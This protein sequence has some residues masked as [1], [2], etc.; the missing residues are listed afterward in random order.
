[1]SL[2]ALVRTQVGALTLDVALTADAG[3]VVALLGPNGAGKTSVLRVLAGLRPLAAGHVRL[4]DEVLD[5]PALDR[6]VEP[7][8]RSIALVFQD[9][10]LFGTM[11][12]LENVAFGLRARGTPKADARHRA[13][14][15]LAALGLRDQAGA[16]P[17]ALSGGQQQ[18][19]ALARA[20]VLSPALLLLDE[21]LAAL[22]ART[23]REVRRELRRH[24]TEFGGAAI[25]VTHDPVDAFA[26]A[27]R[28]V[29]IEHGTVVQQGALVE[30]AARPRSRYVAELVGVNLLQGE[31]QGER[32]V[33][34]TGAVLHTG[35]SEV[36]DGPAMAVVHP[37]AV[38]LHRAKPEG[39]PRNVWSA[40]VDE[41][42]AFGDRARVRLAP[43]SSGHPALTAEI[44][45]DSLVQLHALVGTELWVSVKAT[46]IDTFAM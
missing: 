21:P 38:A 35:A 27:D 41:N 6:F 40:V 2:D 31:R 36:P 7:A 24:L 33:C 8:D 22:D 23:H 12:A 45:P 43:S 34:E 15:Q 18:R 10:L 5:E 11:S 26:L 29:V 13:A 1:M 14:E 3:E 4:N 44:T 46:E 9:Y 30:L 28:V 39:S 32:F 19:V 20:L 42:D 25:V 37:R 17:G 16:R